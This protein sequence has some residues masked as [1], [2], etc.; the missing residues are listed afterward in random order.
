MRRQVSLRI[1]VTVEVA[2]EAE[3]TQMVDDL[4]SD[5]RKSVEWQVERVDHASAV[6]RR[7][8]Q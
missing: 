8:V 4:V 2:D 1:E 7:A 5:A 3:L 6:K